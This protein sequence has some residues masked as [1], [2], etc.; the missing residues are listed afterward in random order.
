MNILIV[1]DDK[2]FLNRLDIALKKRDFKSFKANDFDNALSLIKDTSLDFAILDLELGTKQTGLDVLKEIKNYQNDCKT[3][4]LT[5]YGTVQTTVEAIKIGAINYL[6][7]P[8]S[9]DEILEALEISVSNNKEKELK[10]PTLAE[11]EREHINKVLKDCNGNIT[12]T[13]KILGMHRR[14]LQRKLERN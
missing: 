2:T 3:I 8:V 7:K 9:L 6:T 12:K 5:G 14:S 13:A 4:I 11:I 1:D 10:K